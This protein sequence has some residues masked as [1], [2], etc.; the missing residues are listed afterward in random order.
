MQHDTTGTV[1]SMG[2]IGATITEITEF[3]NSIAAA[4]EEQQAVASEIV[5]NVNQAA[6]G[7]SAI[8]SRIAG[9]A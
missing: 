7:T 9:H 8:A 4:I 3:T 6:Q 2:R 1:Q 5:R